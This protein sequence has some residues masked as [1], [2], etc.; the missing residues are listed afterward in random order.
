L[1][2]ELSATTTRG[3]TISLDGECGQVGVNYKI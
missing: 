3:A 2:S 1:T